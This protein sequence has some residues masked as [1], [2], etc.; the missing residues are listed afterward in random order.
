MCLKSQKVLGKEGAS[1]DTL[2]NEL[3]GD[4]TEGAPSRGSRPVR[5][6]GVLR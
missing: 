2:Q 1:P 3:E 5:Q 4:R 6:G